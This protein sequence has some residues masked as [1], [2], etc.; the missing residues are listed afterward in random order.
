MDITNSLSTALRISD[1][2][3]QWN[4][5]KGHKDGGDKSL[6]LQS[7]SIGGATFWTTLISPGEPG[8]TYTIVPASATYI[9]ASTTSTISFSFD[10]SFD[11][12]LPTKKNQWT[13]DNTESITIT[14]STPGCVGV[15]LS[16]HEH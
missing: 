12:A 8:A 3:V 11:G 9:P 7:A 6:A 1:V 10:K 15:V 4:N 13:W 5:D 2:T 14:L 16:E